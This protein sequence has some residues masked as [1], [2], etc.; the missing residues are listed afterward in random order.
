M[1]RNT[2][3]PIRP[4]W[5]SVNIISTNWP[6]LRECK[7]LLRHTH[8]FAPALTFSLWNQYLL[9][10]LNQY[11]YII[12]S[13]FLPIVWAFLPICELIEM[14]K[15]TANFCIPKMSVSAKIT[16]DA[17][18]TRDPK[19]AEETINGV[20]HDLVKVKIKS[21]LGPPYEQVLT[22]T[23]MLNLLIQE[24]RHIVPQRWFPVLCRD[25][26]GS[27]QVMTRNFQSPASKF[28][29]STWSTGLPT[30]IDSLSHNSRSVTHVPKN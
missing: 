29:S 8:R 22:L 17:A 3:V 1:Y 20:S 24:A 2:S 11:N 10:Q 28:K 18:A 23:Q 6:S 5:R 16:A 26:W 30:D 15:F 19:T 27:H 21:N 9:P 14:V 4:R 13:T 12:N 25:S 7:I